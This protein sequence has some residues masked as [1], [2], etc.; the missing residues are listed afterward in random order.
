MAT[1]NKFPPD[2]PKNWDEAS[3]EIG[4]ATSGL[5]AKAA[6]VADRA[7]ETVKDGYYRARDA[8]TEMDP[9]E[10]AREGGE[11]AIR[12][13]ERHPL[14]AFGLGALSV[15][16]VAWSA[17]RSP[18]PVTRWE[19]YE[20]DFNR[21][22]NL[23]GAYGNDAAKT[24]ESALKSGQQWLQS[25]GAD[26]RDYADYGGRFIASRAQKEPIAALLGVGIAVYVIGSLLT[27]SSEAAPAR[28]R[29]AAKR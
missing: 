21:L 10:T 23:F 1:M 20:P 6:D 5:R 14:I 3:D 11:A 27:A 25:H 8:I 16:L 13:V 22:R 7:T 29:P 9:V 12:A 4:N 24:G 18:P 26:A 28:K 19:R 15:G 17:L 2:V